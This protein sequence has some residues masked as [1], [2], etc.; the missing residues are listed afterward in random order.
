M[1][2][3]AQGVVVA[4]EHGEIPLDRL[5]PGMKVITRDSGL[6][7]VR[8]IGRRCLQWHDLVGAEHLKPLRLAA[9]ALDGRLPEC[10]LLLSPNHRLIAPADRTLLSFQTHE[11]LVPA[12]HLVSRKGASGPLAAEL[13]YLHPLFDRHEI[14]LLN[15]AWS[16]AFHPGD[17]SLNGLGNAQ[18]HEILELFPQLGG[19]HSA[20][21]SEATRSGQ[22][23]LH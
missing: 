14:I 13:E 17:R 21:S 16:E 4:T 6:Q 19:L 1:P 20:A 9:G 7:V 12:K 18:R 23:T 8:W 2:C 22:L 10:G 3:L 15:G 5:R 11:A